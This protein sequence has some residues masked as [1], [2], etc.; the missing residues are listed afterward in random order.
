MVRNRAVWTVTA[1]HADGSI[2]AEGRSGRVRLPKEYVAEHVDLAYARTGA[3]AQGRT[4]DVAILYLEGPT[5]VRNL[6]VPMTRGRSTNEV[7]VA[8]FGEQT[9]LDVVAQSIATDWIDRP[10]IA[11][12]AQLNPRLEAAT[13]IDRPQ[14]E[15]ARDDSIEQILTQWRGGPRKPGRSQQGN[16]RLD[17]DDSTRQ[18]LRKWRGDVRASERSVAVDDSLNQSSTTGGDDSI[19]EIPRSWRARPETPGQSV[20]D[21]GDP[22]ETSESIP[23]RSSPFPE[24]G[25]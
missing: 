25:L 21:I 11:R 8:T 16:R 1:I 6:Y 14:V 2:L 5:D 15:P 20:D 12:R 22:L 9:A 19:R 3:G 23:E 18:I 13:S 24:L 4:V 7:F 10:A 17:A